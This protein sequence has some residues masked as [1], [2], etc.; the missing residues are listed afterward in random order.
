MIGAITHGC[1][2]DDTKREE[3]CCDEQTN[4]A[5]PRGLRTI[6]DSSLDEGDGSGDAPRGMEGENEDGPMS[7]DAERRDVGVVEQVE[8]E[9]EVVG[10]EE[11]LGGEGLFEY[12][13]C[14]REQ[15][16]ARPA[17][18]GPSGEFANEERAAAIHRRKHDEGRQQGEGA[19]AKQEFGDERCK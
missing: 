10:I 16:D 9:F 5:E 19:M 3:K 11:R 14:K 13:V 12:S 2:T 1:C 15:H 7:A 18:P 8:I 4:R 17:A 6:R